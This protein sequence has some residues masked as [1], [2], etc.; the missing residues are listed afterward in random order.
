[1]STSSAF[2]RTS[3]LFAASL[4]A[5][6]F[7]S[8][9]VAGA[10]AVGSASSVRLKILSCNVRVPQPED[11]QAGDGW[12]ARRQLCGDVIVAQRADVVCLQEARGYQVDELKRRLPDFDS[13]GMSLPVREVV[14]NNAIMYS[15]KRF[16]LISSGGFWFSEQ[17]HVAG[18]FGWDTKSPRHANWARL[19]D[20][21]N[22]A[23]FIVWNTHFDHIG[24]QAREEQA[25]M[26]IEASA[27][28]DPVGIPQVLTGDMNAKA[29]NR[30]IEVLKEGGWHD[31]YAALHGPR[32]PGFTFH[33]FK[34]EARKAK[35]G[36]GK[37]DW[38]FT[39]GDIKPLNAEIIRDGRDG[40]Y[41]SDHYFLSATLELPINAK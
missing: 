31:T 32:D 19:R 15:R 33:G 23:E 38:I 25:R 5:V 29:S 6:V 14:Q 35:G 40:R 9:Q 11:E 3:L 22:S 10:D 13:T 30:A 7:S 37:I 41:P 17:P 16:E 26:V 36:G 20:R 34:G 12:E 8:S 1:M 28:F 2:N 24:Q 18:S 27:A 4:L 21:D 39:R